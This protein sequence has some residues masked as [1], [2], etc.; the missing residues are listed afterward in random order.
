MLCSQKTIITILLELWKS[1]VHNIVLLALHAK[2]SGFKTIQKRI[3]FWI[4]MKI[5]FTLQMLKPVVTFSRDWNESE[6]RE[7]HGCG[8]MGEPGCNGHP[9]N[10]TI[11]IIQAQT[12]TFW[13]LFSF[14]WS[15]E[16]VFH[17]KF[18][19]QIRK[20]PVSKSFDEPS[21]CEVRITLI[22]TFWRV[23]TRK[24]FH[25]TWIRSPEY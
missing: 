19:E 25:V 3:F 12:C 20:G 21:Q 22:G 8:E 9:A 10:Q 6:L 14:T 16:V 23:T 4:L 17:I 11:W 7:T 5:Y 1:L 24:L 15:Y 2:I 18:P 13:H